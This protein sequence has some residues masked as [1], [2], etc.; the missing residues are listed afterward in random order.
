MLLLMLWL[1]ELP[2][3]MLIAFPKHSVA[4]LERVNAWFATHGR[5]LL[6]LASGGLGIYLIVVGVVELGARP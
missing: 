2:M 3:L 5:R 1:I 4:A 6:V